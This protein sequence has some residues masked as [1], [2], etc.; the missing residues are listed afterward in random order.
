MNHPDIGLARAMISLPRNEVPGPPLPA[1]RKTKA[2]AKTTTD[3]EAQRE[4]KEALRG[5]GLSSPNSHEYDRGATW[6]PG[7]VSRRAYR[8]HLALFMSSLAVR[9]SRTKQFETNFNNWGIGKKVSSK[10]MQDSVRVDLK[11]RAE[12]SSKAVMFRLRKRQC[13]RPKLS[14]T[15]EIMLSL[16]KRPISTQIDR[17]K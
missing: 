1:S 3:W 2:R 13:R 7:Y 11:C 14:V 9:L 4:Y 15:K 17:S 8:A 6:I 12:N 16:V 10:D 5:R